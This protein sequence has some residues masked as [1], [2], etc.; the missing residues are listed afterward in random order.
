MATHSSVLAWR[1][2]GTA[3]P[4]GLPSMGSHRAG[5]DWSDLA[6]AAA[7]IYSFF[8]FFCEIPILPVLVCLMESHNR[9]IWLI[10]LQICYSFVCQLRSAVE[11]CQWNFHFSY[12]T[13]QFH[14]S[15]LIFLYNLFLLRFS[16]S[17][18][19]CHHTSNSVSMISFGS[20]NVCDSCFEILVSLVQ[21]LNSLRNSFCWLFL[22]PCELH[23]LISLHVL[24]FFVKPS[25]LDNVFSRLSS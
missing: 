1:I 14:N 13:F 20:S 19:H 15:N 24:S 16:I 4:G 17:L 21:E 5:H 8:V 25:I 6:A 12:Y 23:F 18:S 7:V 10:C 11:P 3:E 9:K 22:T 2:P